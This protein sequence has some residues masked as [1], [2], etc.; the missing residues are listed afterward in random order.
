[1]RIRS[2]QAKSPFGAVSQPASP[3]GGAAKSQKQAANPFGGS[4]AQKPFTEPGNTFPDF[5]PDLGIEDIP[6]YKSIGL[7]QVVGFQ[8]LFLRHRGRD[9]IHPCSLH[10][11][12]KWWGVRLWWFLYVHRVP[13]IL[14]WIGIFAG[15]WDF[16][17]LT[18]YR[19]PIILLGIGTF[20]LMVE[21]CCN[22]TPECELIKTW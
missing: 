15:D 9:I 14:L 1:M 18:L 17:I 21:C 2:V 11:R 3:F 8:Q 13:I 10:A 20:A 12:R 4:L 16:Y 5:E 7:T 6:W 22:K 19:V